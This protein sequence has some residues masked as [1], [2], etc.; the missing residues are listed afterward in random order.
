MLSQISS[1]YQVSPETN[2]HA[3]QTGNPTGPLVILLHGLGGSTETFV[4]I[5]PYLN[6]ETN[7]IVS[8]DLEGFGKTGLSSSD[9]ELSIP[10]YVDELESLVALLQKPAESD[11]AA[12]ES[13]QNS[14]Q[15]RVLIIG[16]SL[17]S[18][19]AMH[20]AAKHPE[21][22][23]GLALLGPGRSIAHIPA[24]RERMLS[25]ATKA[26]IEG[27]SAVAEVAAVSNFPAQSGVMVPE[28]LRESVRQAVA[29]C[30]AE[31]YANTCE[32]VAGLDHLDPN[33][34]LI[35]AP[36]LLLAGSGDVISPPERSVG[37]K[38]LIGDNA[39]VTVL[40]NVGHQ[41]ILQ[42]LDGSVKAIRS[43]LDKVNA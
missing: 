10:R 21:H 6:P 43:L 31:A 34:G 22:T 26:R 14:T 40:E 24:A 29:A 7:R 28:G 39:W 13:T 9:I 32:A 5:L 18:I 27:I 1:Y 2:L 8:V 37:L 36:T 11:D 4:P 16:H 19:I 38:E 25:L 41:M 33:Y 12:A 17:G 15:H 23:R 30:K 20:Y 3:A 35:N 42:D